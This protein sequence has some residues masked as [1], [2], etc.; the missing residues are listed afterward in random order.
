MLV[1]G[2]DNEVYRAELDGLTVFARIRQ[3]G[4]ESF[5]TEAWAMDQARNA[6]VPVPKVLYMDH[7][8]TDE[9]PRAAMVLAAAQGTA[10][11]DLPTAPPSLRATALHRSGE[12]LAQL[13]TVTTPGF[14]RPT[15]DGTWPLTDWQSSMSGF[16]RGR[17]TERDLVVS[18]GVSNPDFDHM[19]DLMT[20]YVR[21]YP[22]DQP[23]LCHG[24][25]TP[26]HVFVDDDLHVSD[27]IDF[28][29]FGSGPAVGDLAILNFSLDAED[30]D[31]VMAGYG[32]ESD[33][34]RRAVDLHTIGVAI[35]NLAHEVRIGDIDGTPSGLSRLKAAIQ[36]L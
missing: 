6:G 32:N 15:P 33:H 31:H 18:I 5:S 3:H 2:Y 4:D 24:D 16:I 12:T 28:G 30:F 29:M 14:W 35:G 8:A 20:T 36:R 22:C 1:N 7:I 13:H 10:I 9:G 25:L 26:D 19:V 17:M 21:D 27:V 11:E 23:V 34:F